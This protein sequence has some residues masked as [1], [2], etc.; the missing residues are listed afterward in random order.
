[1]KVRHITETAVAPDGPSVLYVVSV[2]DLKQRRYNTDI[3][4]VPAAGGPTRKLTN[5]PGQDDSPRWSPDGKTVAFL[6]DRDGKPQ[7]WLI[8]PG[9]GEARKLTDSK[10]PVREFAWSP[11][12]KQLAYVARE[13]DTEAEE[14]QKRDKAEV[15]LVGQNHKPDRL[16]LIAPAGGRPRQLVGGKDSILHFDWSPDGRQIVYSVAPTRR[17]EDQF[18]TDLFVVAVEGPKAS[19]GKV[20]PLVRREG[21]DTRPQWSADGKWVAFVSSDGK[22]DWV[23]NT[24]LCV[25]PAAGGAPRN[26][27]REYDGVISAA[28]PGGFGWAHDSQ[29]LYFL[30]DERAG[31]RLFAVS[32]AG[33]AVKPVKTPLPVLDQLSFCPSTREVAFLA[34]DPATPREVYLGFL[35]G[36]QLRKPSRLTTTNPQLKHVA[37]GQVETIRWKSFDGMEIEGLL[38]KPVGYKKGVRYPLLTYIHGGP[39]LQFAR[40]F[41][42]YPPGRPQAS[43]YPVHVLAGEGY[44]IFCPNPRGSNGYGAKFRQANLLDWGGGDFRDIM[45]GVGVLIDEGIADPQRLGVMGWSYGG[46]LTSWAITQTDRF[47][48]ASTGA[49]VS[50]LV[51]AYGQTDIPAFVERYFGGLPWAERERY[52]KHSPVTFAGKIKTPTLIQHGEKDERVPLAQSQELYAALKRNGVPVEFVVY[53]RQGHNPTEPQLQVDVLSRNVEWFNRWLKKRQAP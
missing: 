6:S 41:S 30:A 44:A 13:P 53:P 38:I 35:G 12:G 43:R 49:G 18:Q 22:F 3:W 28:A 29:G 31:R 50:N 27:S 9:G 7:V 17:F 20:R 8:S 1:M 51:S 24:Y 40:G 47:K 25:V 23:G 52:A 2:A 36:D 16:S 4:I 32:L 37:L 34:E 45:A 33:D 11:D 14:Q 26:V 10:T 46:Y 15:R 5:G 19:H 42:V 21:M 48:A 39:A